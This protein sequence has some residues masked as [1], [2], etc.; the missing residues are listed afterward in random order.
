MLKLF[1]IKVS[2]EGQGFE[3]IPALFHNAGNIAEAIWRNFTCSVCLAY[4]AKAGAKRHRK[5]FAKRRPRSGRHMCKGTSG[6]V[7]HTFFIKQE[8][9]FSIFPACPGCP[10]NIWGISTKHAAGIESAEPAL[11]CEK[12]LRRQDSDASLYLFVS[13]PHIRRRCPAPGGKALAGK[14]ANTAVCALRQLGKVV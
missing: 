2:L 12:Y 1:S 6:F 13:C 4:P 3:G 5:R 9:V 14:P 11:F 10:V 8:I 7:L